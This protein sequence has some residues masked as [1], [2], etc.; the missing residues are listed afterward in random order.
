MDQKFLPDPAYDFSTEFHEQ[1][2]HYVNLHNAPEAFCT[3]PD[4]QHGHLGQNDIQI[5]LSGEEIGCHLKSNAEND[6]TMDGNSC[7][8][9]RCSN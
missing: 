9:R 4:Q 5:Q 8:V 6:L 3:L 2:V 7:I 1:K